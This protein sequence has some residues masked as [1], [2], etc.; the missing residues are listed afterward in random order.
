[1]MNQ[2]V[3]ESIAAA[4]N[5]ILKPYGINAE[6]LTNPKPADDEQRYLTVEAAEKYCGIS[7][8]TFG[9]AVKSGKLPQIKLSAARSGK[10]LLDRRD[11]DK[12][13][14]AMKKRKAVSYTA[15]DVAER[16]LNGNQPLEVK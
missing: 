10:I 14:N 13:L 3:P 11:L 8:W 12:W 5:A 16:F 9:R 15:A 2:Q 1:M 6:S 7:R 4:V